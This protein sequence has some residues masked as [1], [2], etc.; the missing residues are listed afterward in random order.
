MFLVKEA[1][2]RTKNNMLL[3]LNGQDWECPLF[4]IFGFFSRMRK[5]PLSLKVSSVKHWLRKF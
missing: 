2:D 4:D 3:T 5:R 1:V